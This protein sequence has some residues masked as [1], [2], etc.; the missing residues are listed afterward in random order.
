MVKKIKK[1]VDD[2]LIDTSLVIEAPKRPEPDEEEFDPT[3]SIKVDIDNLEPDDDNI[4]ILGK[5]QQYSLTMYLDKNV[6]ASTYVKFIKAC[7]R[8]IRSNEDYK[9]YLDSLRELDFFCQ[10]A[11]LSKITSMDAEIQIHHHPLTLYSI[12]SAIVSKMLDSGEKV[13]SF[14]VAD[15]V[16]NLHFTNQVGLT[17]LTVT[18]HEL[19]HMNQLKLQRRQIFGNWEKFFEEHRGYFNDY[20]REVVKTL[21]ERVRIERSDD[22]VKQIGYSKKE[23]ENG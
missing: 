3:K 5:N 14:I 22:T 2:T 16:L 21:V 12:T 9:L 10:D 20:D 8:G 13:S 7:E 18:N 17:P 19:A 15:R 6:D 1:V 11:F 23:Q 4:E